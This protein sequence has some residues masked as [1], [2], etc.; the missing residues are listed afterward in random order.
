M[1]KFGPITL[2]EYRERIRQLQDYDDAQQNERMKIYDNLRK[3]D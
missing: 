1:D 3:E 2:S